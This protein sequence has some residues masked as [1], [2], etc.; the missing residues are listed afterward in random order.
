MAVRRV[1]RGFRSSGPG[2]SASLPAQRRRSWRLAAPV[3]VRACPHA[4]V[5][6][7]GSTVR[8]HHRPD[9]P[10]ARLGATWSTASS[11]RCLSPSRTDPH[12]AWCRRPSTR[13]TG[14]VDETIAWVVV[15]WG[16][17][18][19][20]V[21]RPEASSPCVGPTCSSSTVTEHDDQQQF[22]GP[23]RL[24]P[25]GAPRHP[26]SRRPVRAPGPRWRW[27]TAPDDVPPPLQLSAPRRG[28]HHVCMQ[29]VSHSITR[30]PQRCT[31]RHSTSLWA[32]FASEAG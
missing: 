11:T 24:A 9:D 19:H 4:L 32:L 13:A 8:E 18:L 28:G 1:L 17:S 10:S 30:G 29:R 16:R 15:A 5:H 26:R 31:T 2:C 21:T 25:G 14:A 6:V 22:R 12:C 20:D 27:R 7:Q 23:C 3:S